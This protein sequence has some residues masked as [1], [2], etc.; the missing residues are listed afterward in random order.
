[1][2]GLRTEYSAEVR[3]RGGVLEKGEERSS[4]WTAM[5]AIAEAVR[6]AIIDAHACEPICW[7]LP[8]PPLSY[9]DHE[10]RQADAVRRP[11]RLQPGGSSAP[12]STRV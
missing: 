1:M 7:Q 4:Q 9:L 3:A 12:R 2:F 8:I 10:A 5:E 11:S 6:V